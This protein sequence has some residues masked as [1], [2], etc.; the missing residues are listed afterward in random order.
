MLGTLW[1]NTTGIGG[2]ATLQL[3]TDSLSC[4]VSGCP[5]DVDT[6]IEFT[7]FDP[8]N[9]DQATFVGATLSGSSAFSIVHPSDSVRTIHPSDSIV[10]RYH[11]T[12][13]SE[14]SAALHLRLH[15]GFVDKDTTISLHGSSRVAPAVPILSFSKLSFDHS[16]CLSTDTAVSITYR[17][18]CSG[19]E[20]TLVQAKLQ[21]SSNFILL[22]P[23][24]SPRVLTANDSIRIRFSATPGE[25]DTAQLFLRLE[26][27]NT[28]ID[29]T[30]SIVGTSNKQVVR[31]QLSAT[32]LSFAAIRCRSSLDS[33]ITFVFIDSCSGQSA[34]LISATL[35]GSQSFTLLSPWDVPRTTH[36]GDSIV[37]HYAPQ[38]SGTDNAQLLLKFRLGTS[39]YD[40]TI[41]L[42]GAG[43]IQKENL[44][45]RSAFITPS[46]ATGQ[47]TN[48]VITPDKAISSRG[49]SKIEFDLLYNGDLLEKTAEATNV[50][51]AT[52]VTTPL[53]PF[54]GK[55]RGV[56]VVVNANDMSLDPTLAIA[57]LTFKAYLTDTT[58]TTVA[59]S[60]LQL[61]DGDQDFSNC[62]LSA[63]TSATTFTLALQCGD[64]I[65]SRFLRTKGL[66]IDAIRPNPS[67]GA[68]RLSVRSAAAGV[69]EI[70]VVNT[71]GE[72]VWQEQQNI[73]NGDAMIR[74]DLGGLANGIYYLR[75]RTGER[76]CGGSLVIER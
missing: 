75:V 55:E 49:L 29:T 76:A 12:G 66:F 65:L 7:F 24:D 22:S 16:G 8:C 41:T 50:G 43:R 14:D 57:R 40:T 64:S 25:T 1:S 3:S 31:P 5:S 59:I 56:H 70:E 20:G 58:S 63:D 72:V 51:G 15:L 17:D 39:E 48:L 36:A 45:L 74:L 30:I 2:D 13:V 60:N 28:E 44:T 23:T 18:T 11:G 37:I 47:T 34:D 73:P 26:L 19:Q 52:I 32:T 46:V 42:T 27:G 71:L 62:V 68:V 67:S 69:A 10:L 61:N 33:V 4:N 21:G 38:M 53:T 54:L 9:G 35:V 6:A